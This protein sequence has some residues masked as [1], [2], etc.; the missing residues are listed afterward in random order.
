MRMRLTERVREFTTNRSLLTTKFIT[1]RL[2]SDSYIID[3]HE[4]PN[5]VLVLSGL[6][7]VYVYRLFFF[8]LL[9][10]HVLDCSL[11]Q[12]YCYLSNDWL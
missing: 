7:C 8:V 3:P 5:Q 11:A 10:I 1:N 2:G 12:F 6:V 4:L 9:A